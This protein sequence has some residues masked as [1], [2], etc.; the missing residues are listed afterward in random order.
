[1]PQL[2]RRLVRRRLKVLMHNHCWRPCI[3]FAALE[4]GY[5]LD[6]LR[7]VDKRIAIELIA[8]NSGVS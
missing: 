6:Q 5:Q 2:D 7:M 4:V 8:E 1:M 3:Y